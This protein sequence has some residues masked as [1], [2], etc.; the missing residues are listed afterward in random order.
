[1]L[2]RL[3]QTLDIVHHTPPILAR[4]AQPLGASGDRGRVQNSEATPAEPVNRIRQAISEFL[5]RM[6]P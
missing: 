4:S 6:M 1:M 5:L 3:N 2:N